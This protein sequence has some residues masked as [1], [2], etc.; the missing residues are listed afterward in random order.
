MQEGTKNT[1]AFPT[2]FQ[3]AERPKI[4]LSFEKLRSCTYFVAVSFRTVKSIFGF[5]TDKDGNNF[6]FRFL[7][8]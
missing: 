7:L 1:F 4:F 5:A 6:I 8:N 2:T 3:I